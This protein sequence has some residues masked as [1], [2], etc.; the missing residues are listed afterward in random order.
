MLVSSWLAAT[1]G[2]RCVHNV[3]AALCFMSHLLRRT[4]CGLCALLAV[5]V[6]RLL[7]EVLQRG[8]KVQH[9]Q[10][11]LGSVERFVAVSMQEIMTW[12][13]SWSKFCDVFVF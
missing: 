7:F 8:H 13:R 5:V 3:V 9:R 4:R 2:R 11:P 12:T 10:Q 6:S 1:L